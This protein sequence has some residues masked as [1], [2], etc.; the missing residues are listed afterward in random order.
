MHCCTKDKLKFLLF[1]KEVNF[2]KGVK[3]LAQISLVLFVCFHLDLS[4]VD[5][6]IWFFFVSSKIKPSRSDK[7]DY[8]KTFDIA[9]QGFFAQVSRSTF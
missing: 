5:L 3:G 1:L 7:S 8:L 4:S 2:L 6:I 9:W